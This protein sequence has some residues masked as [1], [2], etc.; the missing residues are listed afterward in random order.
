MLGTTY[1]L[2]VWVLVGLHHLP[3]WLGV[4]VLIL[5]LITFGFYGVDKFAA[6]SGNWRTPETTLLALGLLGGWPGGYIA[7][8]HFRHKTSKASFQ[9]SFW[10]TVAVNMVVV[11]GF[12]FGVV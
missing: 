12:G 7:Q 2:G 1:L 6:Q 4:G 9:T 3:A 5:S 8:Q 11:L 10:V